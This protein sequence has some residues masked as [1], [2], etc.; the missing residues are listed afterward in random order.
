MLADAPAPAEQE[1][2]TDEEILRNK[3]KEIRNA[4]EKYYKSSLIKEING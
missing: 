4:L 3:T 1:K 2:L